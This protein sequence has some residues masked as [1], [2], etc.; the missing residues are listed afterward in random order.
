MKL[1]I[2]KIAF[3]LA[4]FPLALVSSLGA[5]HA[6]DVIL[7]KGANI[8]LIFDNR[9]SSKTAKEG[10]KVKFHVAED[11]MANNETVISEGTH[12][13]GT[14][15][16]VKKR[17]RFGVNARI[18]LLMS[19]IMTVSGKY[20]PLGFKSKWQE[21][22]GKTGEATAASVGSAVIL[23]PLGLAAGYFVVGKTVDAKLGDKITVEV[24][25][26]TFIKKSN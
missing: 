15:T 26:D 20:A 12:V 17:G 9:L 7:H 22:G 5:A 4:L 2:K 13:T 18:Q 14:V 24:T 6:E 1:T 23:G 16:K 21:I 10:D 25:Q 8:V 19:N 11:V 3:S